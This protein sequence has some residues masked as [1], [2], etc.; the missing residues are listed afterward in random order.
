M[1]HRNNKEYIRRLYIPETGKYLF[2]YGSRKVVSEYKDFLTRSMSLEQEIAFHMRY[3]IK[4]GVYDPHHAQKMRIR[5][6]RERAIA[7]KAYDPFKNM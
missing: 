5:K 2:I 1:E 7:R 6:E 4:D 3:N